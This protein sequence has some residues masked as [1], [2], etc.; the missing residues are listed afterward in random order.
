MFTNP[1]MIKILNFEQQMEHGQ[2]AYFLSSLT[3]L[4][5]LALQGIH[6]SESHFVDLQKI[7]VFVH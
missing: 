7:M 4:H 3:E 6:R 5:I 2:G 1:K